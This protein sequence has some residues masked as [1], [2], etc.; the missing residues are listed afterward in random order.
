M[1]TNYSFLP[2][3]MLFIFCGG[4]VADT[5]S[6][7]QNGTVTAFGGYEGISEPFAFDID[8]SA[9][10]ASLNL[11]EAVGQP[12]TITLASNRIQTGIVES[13][14]QIGVSGTQGLYRLRLA[15]KLAKL[16]YIESSRTFADLK[17]SDLVTQIMQDGGIGDVSVAS[18]E[19]VHEIILQH[20]ETD[21]NFVSRLL[22]A[23]GFHYHFRQNGAEPVISDS[24]ADFASLPGSFR[25][26][27]KGETGIFEFARGEKMQSTRIETGDY[28]WLTPNNQP[29]GLKQEAKAY[30]T[31]RAGVFPSG[32]INDSSAQAMA[33]ILMDQENSQAQRCYG[34]SA[35]PQ[36]A[37]GHKFTLVGHPRA[38]FNIVYLVTAVRHE[39]A[40]SGYRNEFTCQPA[41]VK[42]RP[43]MLTPKP[44]IAGILSGEVTGPAGESKYPD[45][46][47]RVQ[48]KFPWRH[49]GNGGGAGWIRVL[50]IAAGE[51][52]SALW[53]PNVGDEVA[54]AFENGDP[55]RPV[56]IGSLFNGGN[57]PPLQLPDKKE[58]TVLRFDAIGGQRMQITANTQA[59]K[60]SLT[61]SGGD[62][63]VEIDAAGERIVLKNAGTS[64]TLDKSNNRLTLQAADSLL[65]LDEKGI[66]ANKP[67]KGP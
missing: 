66:S 62:S 54:V 17:V 46:H 5:I 41:T 63:Y 49:S 37:A 55:N 67:I 8:I 58:Q 20:R 57:E 14:E 60:E 64:V 29:A 16:K 23:E 27:T 12:I 26:S 59:G 56:V 44:V 36:L 15:P 45:E 50:Q 24:N 18:S 3:L 19:T 32:S 40:A 53:V 28:A 38:D 61:L 48:V 11:G 39:K 52:N 31:L 7:L 65:V 25:F 1:R 35:Y 9:A 21:L 6:T 22:E 2:G 43:R 47:G 42:Y 30:G 33:E 13:L 51:G 34:K 4:A 10:G